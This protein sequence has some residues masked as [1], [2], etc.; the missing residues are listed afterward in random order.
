MFSVYG[1]TGKVFTGTVEQLRHIDKVN[2]LARLRR[3]EPGDVDMPPDQTVQGL[4]GGF[5]GAAPSPQSPVRSAI[6]AYVTATVPDTPRQP[7]DRVDLLMSQPAITVR[8]EATL[9]EASALLSQHR[10]G[11]MPV[12]DGLGR[13]VGLLLRADLFRPQ[14]AASAVAPPASASTAVGPPATEPAPEPA[15]PDWDTLMAQPVADLM[16]TPVPSVSADTDIRRVARVL[17][18]TALPGLP[19]VDDAGGVTGFVSRTDILRAVASDPPLDV[20]G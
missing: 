9:G 13:L 2:A 12:V 18:D 8:A 19:V 3:I 15:A 10:I 4:P 14:R 6:A 5:A 16:W 20:W 17:L 7:L 1:V 11:Q